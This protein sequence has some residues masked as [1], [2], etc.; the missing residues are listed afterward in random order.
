MYKL[1][2][3]TPP[4]SGDYLLNLKMN[5]PATTAEQVRGR[6]CWIY[7]YKILILIVIKGKSS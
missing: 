3:K 5:K 6:E 7:D 1:K 4:G 2:C